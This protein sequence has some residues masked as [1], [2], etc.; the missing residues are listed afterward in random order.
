V[1]LTINKAKRIRP[2]A[3]PRVTGAFVVPTMDGSIWLE[4]PGS[5]G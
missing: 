1:H 2:A 5:F 3:A 4:L